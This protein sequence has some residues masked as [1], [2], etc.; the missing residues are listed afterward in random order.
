MKRLP[1]A[2][3]GFTGSINSINVSTVTYL[4]MAAKLRG[5]GRNKKTKKFGAKE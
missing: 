5:G 3:Y 1:I 2:V 4:L